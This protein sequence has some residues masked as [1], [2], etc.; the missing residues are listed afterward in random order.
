MVYQNKNNERDSE[1]RPA[2]NAFKHTLF[3][4]LTF[5]EAYSQGFYTQNGKP[6]YNSKL[7]ASEGITELIKMQ[8][9]KYVTSQIEKAVE[10]KLIDNNLANRELPTNFIKSERFNN[11]GSLVIG[12]IFSDYVLSNIVANVESTKLFVGDIKYFLPLSIYKM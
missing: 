3:P 6:I 1:G 11:L 9:E 4:E 5:G 2:G 8:Y 12:R 7:I 10:Y